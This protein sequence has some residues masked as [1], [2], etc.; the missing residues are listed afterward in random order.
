MLQL[1]DSFLSPNQPS[2]KV[3]GVTTPDD[4]NELA[5]VGVSALG[6]NFWPESRRYCTPEHARHFLPS[7]S[8]RILRVGVFV[9]ADP[10]LPRRLQDEGLIDVAQFHGDEDY[11][12]CERYSRE[13]LPFFKA[14][15][16]GD[17]SD[18]PSALQYNA[19]ALLLDAH[20][21]GVYGGTGR[22]ID[23]NTAASFVEE[24]SAPPI[25]LAGG[26]TAENA[27]EALLTSQ[28]CALDIASGAES[29][30]GIK[31]FGK[32]ASLLEVLRSPPQ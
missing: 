1:L 6:I 5:R 21:P 14:I 26:I 19:T 18:V 30:P 27:A 31:D 23:W 9:N 29:S 17:Q 22:T 32:I 25:I 28:P 12:Y 3:C 7:L 10:D 2:L 15:G 13:G 8:D 20:A 11:S 24:Q 4:A 16:V